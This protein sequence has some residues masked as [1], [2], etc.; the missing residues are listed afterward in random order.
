[1]AERY[2]DGENLKKIDT[3]GNN[4]AVLEDNNYDVRIQVIDNNNV[5]LATF[6]I[7]KY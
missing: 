3:I 7:K 2:F 6:F 1:M 4:V 5:L